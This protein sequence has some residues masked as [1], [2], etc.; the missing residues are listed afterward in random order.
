MILHNPSFR[1]AFDFE[2]RP[3]EIQNVIRPRQKVLFSFERLARRHSA[4]K[5]FN[6]R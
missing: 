6:P 2:D 1:L 4:E 5:F 3:I